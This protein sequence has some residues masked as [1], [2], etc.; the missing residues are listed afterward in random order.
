MALVIGDIIAIVTSFLYAYLIRTHLDSRP[1]Y[2]VAN[3]GKFTLAIMTLLPVWIFVLFAFGL[4][5]KKIIMN[6]SH[7]PEVS[8]LFAASIIGVMSIITVDFF[9]RSEEHT[10]ELQSR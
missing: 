6:R 4:Y 2:F 3:P 10:S 9:L 5:S 1:Y 8:R 7:L